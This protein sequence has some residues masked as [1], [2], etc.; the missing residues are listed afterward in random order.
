MKID[1]RRKAR[2]EKGVDLWAKANYNGIFNYAP[3]VGKT[4][5]TQ[6]CIKKLEAENKEKRLSYLILVPNVELLKQWQKKNS[7]MPK[8]LQNRIIIKTPLTLI[9]TDAIYEVD[10]LIIDEIHHY[11]TDAKLP[12]INNTRIKCDKFIGLSGTCNDYEFKKI[13][14]YR[15]IIDVISTEEARQEGFISDFI[16]YNLSVNL[17][18]KER[19]VYNDYSDKIDVLSSIFPSLDWVSRMLYGGKDNKGVFYSGLMYAKSLAIKNNWSDTM[20]LSLDENKRINEV[21]NPNTLINKAHN[22]NKL[23]RKR[24]ELLRLAENKYSI[25]FDLVKKYKTKTIIFSDSTD[26]ADNIHALLRRSNLKAYKYHTNLKPVMKPGKTGKLIKFGLT[27]QKN[28][29]LH[30]FTTIPDSIMCTTRC[31]S[32]GI[33]VPD[34]TLSIIT[35]GSYNSNDQEQKIGRST[36]KNEGI[37]SILFNVYCKDTQEEKS[38]KSRQKGAEH[39]ILFIDNIDTLDNED[40]YVKIDFL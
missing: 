25:T 21:W 30:S 34:I 13:L 5:T 17:T 37:V 32:T 28:E 31:L 40:Q 4:Y 15:P 27:R 20:D 26:F 29:A 35:S 6:L 23:I 24:L 36:R 2:Q 12:L 16:E 8:G 22:L 7:I 18:E 19:L 10:V 39:E 1:E 33:D 14:R 38:L 9:N 3:G 11:S